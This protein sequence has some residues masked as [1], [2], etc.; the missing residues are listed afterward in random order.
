MVSAAPTTASSC[1]AGSSI[2]ARPIA[3]RPSPA[4]SVS[5]SS[6]AIAPDAIGRSRVRSTYGSML[7]SAK[8]FSTHPAERMTTTP[9]TK[10]ANR[11]WS[12][13]PCPASHSAHNV[14]HSRS[15]I[16]IGLSSRISL[17]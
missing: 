15:Q 13:R 17:L 4:N 5:A 6:G 3:M 14:G 9:M 12:G 10:I 16:P 8:S 1:A 7:R 2:E 11:C